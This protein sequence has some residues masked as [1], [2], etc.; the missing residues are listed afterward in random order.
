MAGDW[1]KMRVNLVTHPKVLAISEFL[2]TS[3][4]YQDWSTMSGFVPACGGSKA[5]YDRDFQ[6]SLRVT[7][8][9]TVCALLRFWGYANEH[10]KDEFITTLRVTDLDDIVQVPSFGAAL[11]SIEWVQYD[12]IRKGL[13]L[14]NFNEYNSSAS[15]RSANAKS[16]AER[17]KE[18]RD[19]KKEA[20][21]RDVTRDVT[22]TRNSN[23]REE[24]RR[25]E[26]INTNTS[27][28]PKGAEATPPFVL[29]DWIN[30]QHWD[31]WHSTPKRKK[32]TP[33]QKQMAVDKLDAWRKANEDYAGALENAAIGGN[34]GLFLPNKPATQASGETAYQRSMREKYEQIA[35]SIAAKAPGARPISPNQ[36]FDALPPNKPLEI[37][38]V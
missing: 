29:P 27:L 23:R 4:D 17:Q 15:E 14:P 35:P 26:K 13:T 34:Q 37:T 21:K 22:V 36:F 10:A 18:Y 5:Q 33:A 9:V 3:S 2:A 28:P 16:A 20:E 6:E 11:E 32:A 8:Y 31:T 7:R 38:N 12:E 25:E 1:I 19:R 30:A 24:K